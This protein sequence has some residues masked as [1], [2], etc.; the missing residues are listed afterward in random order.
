MTKE[1]EFVGYII[2]GKHGYGMS[3]YHL[4]LAEKLYIKKYVEGQ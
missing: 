2:E 4:K 3:M 1:K